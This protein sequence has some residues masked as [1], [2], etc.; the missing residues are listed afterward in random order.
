MI[1]RI[2]PAPKGPMPIR[3]PV[4]KPEP[5]HAIRSAYVELVLYGADDTRTDAQKDILTRTLRE[6]DALEPSPK[7]QL[8]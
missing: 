2:P 1:E 4:S 5:K 3:R 6:L 8:R 7:E